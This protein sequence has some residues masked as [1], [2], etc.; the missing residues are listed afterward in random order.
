MAWRDQDL[1]PSL[2]VLDSLLF[3]MFWI[4]QVS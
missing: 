4:L 2:E 1:V 3:N